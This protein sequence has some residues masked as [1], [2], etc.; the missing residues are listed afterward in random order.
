MV[1]SELQSVLSFC[2]QRGENLLDI[3]QER[4]AIER[5]VDHHRRVDAIDAQRRDQRR[6]LPVSKWDR[7]TAGRT[8]DN[9][10]LR[11]LL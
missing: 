3:G 1:V 7:R 10:L 5:A 8:V 11:R 2:E 6:R 4:A 9:D